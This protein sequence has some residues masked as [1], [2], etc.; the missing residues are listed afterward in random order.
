M[1]VVVTPL[2]LEFP[3]EEGAGKEESYGDP[4]ELLW[5]NAGTA[6]SHHAHYTLTIRLRYAECRDK[7]G[8]PRS[9]LQLWADSR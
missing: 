2:Q 6:P 5:S 8:N 7:S 4:M 3:G 9:G 1:T